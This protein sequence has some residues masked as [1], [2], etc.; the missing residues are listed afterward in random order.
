VSHQIAGAFKSRYANNNTVVL[1]C[2]V[3]TFLW[4]WFCNFGNAGSLK[5]INMLDKSS[6]VASI[7]TGNFNVS[8]PPY[9]LNG[10]FLDYMYFVVDGIYPPGVNLLI[11]LVI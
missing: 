9:N 6:I 4:I 1:E 11:L 2:V 7:W 8:C 5:D 10:T 3:A